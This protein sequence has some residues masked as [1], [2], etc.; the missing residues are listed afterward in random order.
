M[1]NNTPI[2]EWAPGLIVHIKEEEYGNDN[3]E[4]NLP[5]PL[6]MNESVIENIVSDNGASNDEASTTSD[7]EQS[8]HNPIVNNNDI[9]MS[10]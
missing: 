5:E 9:M 8:I 1:P 6:F 7:S 4:D 2:F 3:I 10:P